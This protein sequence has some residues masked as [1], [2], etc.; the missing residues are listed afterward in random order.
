VL[1]LQ[2]EGAEVAGHIVVQLLV[3]F[4][5]LVQLGLL[6]GLAVPAYLRRLRLLLSILYGS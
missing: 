5:D 1:L 2:L 6:D 4:L 3:C